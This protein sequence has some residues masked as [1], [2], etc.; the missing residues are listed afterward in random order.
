MK[1]LMLVA[2]MV[3]L[4]LGMLVT[5]A[6]ARRLGGSRSFGMTR[7]SSV[8]KREAIPPRA[9][10]PM[11]GA[12]PTQAAKPTAAA[13]QP[14]GMSRWLG[15]L[16]GLAA[17]VGLAALLSHFG[18]GEAMANFLL[19]ALIAMVAMFV[20]RLLLRK[21]E[22]AA[23]SFQYAGAHNNVDSLETT[24]RFEPVHLDTGKL[25]AG[26]TATPALPGAIATSSLAADGLPADF[27]SEAF[28]RQAKLNFI[29]LQAAN[30]RGDMEDIRQ[31][32]T[33]EV[34]AEIQ[35]QYQERGHSAQQTDVI[36]LEAGVLDVSTEP[37]R[38][39]ISV[40]FSGQ[41]REDA[42]AAPEDFAEV[43]HLLKPIDGS[44]GWLVAGIQQ[45][46]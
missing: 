32:T 40:R 9:A 30:D 29:R 17:G 27:D 13:P 25:G 31:F 41:L 2:M 5:D 23:S 21:R 19:I 11:Q 35:M 14:G 26:D 10:T 39:V 42:N 16:A 44:H 45:M 3:V 8:M 33:P 22:P 28:L 1:K 24:S 46:A 12:A 36:R 34:A 38:H 20:L 6:E 15:P 7:D 4:G 18:M 43:W 37:T